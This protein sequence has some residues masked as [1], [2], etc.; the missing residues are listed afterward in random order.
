VLRQLGAA[1]IGGN[2]GADDQSNRADDR[3]I[4]QA[5]ALDMGIFKLKFSMNFFDEHLQSPANR[6]GAAGRRLVGL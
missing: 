2:D 3:R 6:R 5:F 1:M 4:N